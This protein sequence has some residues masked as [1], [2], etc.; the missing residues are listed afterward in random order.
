M[1]IIGRISKGSKM[2]QI[3]LPK[4]H[5]GFHTG[6]YVVIKPLIHE[7]IRKIEKPVFYHIDSLS[8]VKLQIIYG[9]FSVIDKN[10]HDFENIIITGS[11]LDHGFN[12]NDID[13]LLISEQKENIARLKGALEES[14]GIKVH[15]I[16]LSNE[17]L[18]KGLTSDPLYENMLSKCISKKRIV[19]NIKRIINYQILDLHLLK[20]KPLI[21]N[22]DFFTGEEK[23]Y[24]TKNMIAILLFIENKKISNDLID[25]KIREIFQIDA[26][27]IKQNLL[28]KS[29][30]LKKYK[31]IYNKIFNLITKN[32]EV[33]NEPK[34][35]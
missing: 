13:I 32:E 30:F 4:N 15:I 34:Q 33:K 20:S 5:L 19:F 26:E 6:N 21:D 10:A 2:N 27:K 3:Y 7:N 16:Q 1:E 17:A 22:F 25:K 11:F 18:K 9:I 31:E 24:L 35:K 23:Y 12:F 29:S 8:P 28:D 14:L